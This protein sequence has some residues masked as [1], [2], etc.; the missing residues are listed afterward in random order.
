[1]KAKTVLVAALAGGV[2]Y[3]LGTR[4]GREKYE[5]LKARANDLAHSQ[6]AQDAAARVA[7]EVKERAA[8][9][10]DPVA[11]VINTAADAVAEAP[12]PDTATGST[13]SASA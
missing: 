8:T 11:S 13:P 4:A 7:A 2:G 3:V 6:Q 9:L 5:E 1:M 12:K 10:P